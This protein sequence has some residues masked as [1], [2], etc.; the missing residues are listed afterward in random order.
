[1]I[2]APPIHPSTYT[3]LGENHSNGSRTMY[4]PPR[5]HLGDLNRLLDTGLESATYGKPGRL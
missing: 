1:M 4:E 5:Q 3:Q 2:L